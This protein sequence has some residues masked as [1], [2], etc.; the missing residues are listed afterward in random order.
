MRLPSWLIR[1]SMPAALILG[2]ALCAGWKWE[3]VLP[4]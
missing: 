4:H 1:F 2:S 3:S